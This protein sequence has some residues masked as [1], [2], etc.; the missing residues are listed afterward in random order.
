MPAPYYGVSGCMK[1]G[2]GLD[3]GVGV[4]AV[5]SDAASALGHRQGGNS[6]SWSREARS[7]CPSGWEVGFACETVGRVRGS[8]TASWP[9]WMPAYMAQWPATCDVGWL[10]TGLICVNMLWSGGSSFRPGV[11]SSQA[12][13]SGDSMHESGRGELPGGWCGEVDRMGCCRTM[14]VERRSAVYGEVGWV[15][16][17]QAWPMSGLSALS[18]SQRA[19]RAWGSAWTAR[20]KVQWTGE[21]DSRVAGRGHWFLALVGRWRCEW[22]GGASVPNEGGRARVRWP[23]VRSGV[24][25]PQQGWVWCISALTAWHDGRGL[26]PNP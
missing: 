15:I 12:V 7:Q 4:G 21:W 16:V 8:A 5:R 18:T 22:S 1:R 19:G 13:M 10:I 24:S 20:V 23:R 9:W 26:G 11:T 2:W 25:H 3:Q 14:R 6:F 17:A